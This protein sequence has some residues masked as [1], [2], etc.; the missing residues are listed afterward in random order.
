MRR[1]PR[2]A[3]ARRITIRARL[4]TSRRL[5]TD[6][7]DRHSRERP[8]RSRRCIA[9]AI[10]VV[11]AYR[12]AAVA[13]RRDAERARRG[14]AAQRSPAEPYRRLPRSRR[15]THAVPLPAGSATPMRAAERARIVR[16]LEREN[17]RAAPRRMSARRAASPAR[18]LRRRPARAC[19]ASSRRRAAETARYRQ[20]VV[21]LENNA[22]PPLLDGPTRPTTS[23]SSSASDRCSSA[24]CTS[25]ASRPTARSRAGASATST[26][27][28]RKLPEFPGRIRRD[29][30]VT[31]ARALHQSKYGETLPR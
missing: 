23:S 27:S 7:P 25:S 11:V 22:P 4:A 29:G 10:G 17:A 16:S 21:D 26:S 8:H 18:R 24:C 1:W 20:L 14:S 13:A 6:L 30:W 15:R 5:N 31:Q 2:D 12:R 9:L 28:T 3:T 19:C